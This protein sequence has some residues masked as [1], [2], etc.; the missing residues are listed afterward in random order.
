MVDCQKFVHYFFWT[1]LYDCK[2]FSPFSTLLQYPITG[3]LL[4]LGIHEDDVTEEDSATVNLIKNEYLDG[5]H[6]NFTKDNWARIAKIFSDIN[7][8]VPLDIEARSLVE[9]SS[10][11][12]YYYRN[13]WVLYIPKIIVIGVR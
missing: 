6:T 10:Q 7:Y 2:P 12:V 11:P 1:V 8:L 4:F 13:K 5:L 3:P 9:K